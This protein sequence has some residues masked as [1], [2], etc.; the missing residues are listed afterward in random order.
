MHSRLCEFPCS[1]EPMTPDD[2]SPLHTDML[3]PNGICVRFPGITVTATFTTLDPLAASSCDRPWLL[4]GMPP[5]L[6][7]HPP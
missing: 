2:S 4:E 6:W 7:M 5:V 1:F 3:D